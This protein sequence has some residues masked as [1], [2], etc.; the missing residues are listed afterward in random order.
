MSTK[1]ASPK[2][3]QEIAPWVPGAV[4]KRIIGLQTILAFCLLCCTFLLTV[5]LW[6]L[7][8]A[9]P[10]LITQLS[11]GQYAAVQTS[12]INLNM[13]DV[14]NF[15]QLILPRLYEN[16]EGAAP[17]IEELRGLNVINPNIVDGFL[18]DVQRNINQMK[19]G[20]FVQSAIVQSV[21]HKTLAIRYAQKVVYAEATGV[22][23]LT[24]QSGHSQTNPTQWAM[25]FYIKDI[26]D[27]HNTIV[28][29]YGLYLQNIVPQTPG[30][31]NPTAPKPTGE[32]LPGNS[33][34]ATLEQTTPEAPP[35]PSTTAPTATPA[36]PAQK[37]RP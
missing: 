21:N 15:I 4:A 5:I 28:N 6:K 36:L 24:D 37:T 26:I 20:H 12:Q 29:R 31:S 34:T 30:T 23:I 22:V 1:L 33:Q 27:S 3:A 25:L 11:N 13:D 18:A 32:E 7:A 9:P 19:Q 16:S 10:R 17:G 8:T 14:T 2:H 35:L